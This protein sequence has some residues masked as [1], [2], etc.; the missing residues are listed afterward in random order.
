MNYTNPNYVSAGI[1]YSIY[2]DYSD[3]TGIKSL[4]TS[5][6][7]DNLQLINYI[8]LFINDGSRFVMIQAGVNAGHGY[9]SKIYFPKAFSHTPMVFIQQYAPY[10]SNNNFDNPAI[11]ELDEAGFKLKSYAYDYKSFSYFSGNKSS[12]SS[13]D[14]YRLVKMETVPGVCWLAIGQG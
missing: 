10:D 4:Y 7:G 13:N 2:T 6:Q 8:L 14:N 9:E 5:L 3:S 11:S 1:P 12:F